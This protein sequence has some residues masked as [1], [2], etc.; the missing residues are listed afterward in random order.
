MKNNS[1]GKNMP[2]V[3]MIS[4]GTNL[5][6]TLKTKN[7][8]RIAGTLEGEAHAKGKLIISSSGRVEG[9]V[10]AVDADIAGNL[11]GE[12]RVNNKLI[13]RKSAIIDGDIYAKNLLVEEGAQINGTCRMGEQVS[14]ISIDFDENEQPESKSNLKAVETR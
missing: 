9:D 7:D 11:E 10:K 8:I 14:S 12:I 1:T 2:S 13:L 6:G 4:E 5:K 3:N